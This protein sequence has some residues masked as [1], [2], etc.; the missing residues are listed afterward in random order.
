M[1]AISDADPYKSATA[2]VTLNPVSITLSP[3]SITLGGGA[4]QTFTP[5]LKYASTSDITWYVETTVGGDITTVGSIVGGLYTAPTP[6]TAQT[7]VTVKAVPVAD[8][9]KSATAQ[10]TLNPVKVTVSPDAPTVRRR[11]VR[12]PAH[13]FFC[14]ANMPSGDK[15][16][17][18]TT[19]K[20]QTGRSGTRGW[21]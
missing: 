18:V 14:P 12:P 4:T 11:Y 21:G 17:D 2:Q 19:P 7:I 6:V 8:P 9:S 3:D 15:R 5:D 10:V 13:P 1:K 16:D 20:E